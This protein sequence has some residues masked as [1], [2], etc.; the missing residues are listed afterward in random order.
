MV[1]VLLADDHTMVRS[2]LRQ[3]LEASGEVRVVNEAATAD[4]V[5][6][7]CEAGGFD[8]AL[9][10][11]HMPGPGGVV[12]LELLRERHP[13]LRMLV[14]S[15]HNDAQVIDRAL[16]AGAQGYVTKEADLGVLLEAL[17]AVAAGHSYIDPGVRAS[18]DRLTARAGGRGAASAATGGQEALHE[19]LSN[20]ERQVLALIA[21]GHRLGDIAD[22][23]RVSAKTVSTHKMRLMDK[24]GVSNNADLLKY[25]AFHGIGEGA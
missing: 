1:D 7:R 19:L 11:L 2:S 17:R 5:L 14:L 13:G 16:R 18:V 12:L 23:L 20:R 10:D 9:L 6:A 22:L 24:L 3:V 4:E 8:L 21:R 15:M 25:V